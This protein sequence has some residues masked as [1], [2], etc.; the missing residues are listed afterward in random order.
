MIF[1]SI[2]LIVDLY[3]DRVLL[4]GSELERRFQSRRLGEAV[5]PF[6]RCVRVVLLAKRRRHCVKNTN[7]A[8]EL[9]ANSDFAVS[10]LNRTGRLLP[11]CAEPSGRFV[12]PRARKNSALNHDNP[13]TR[14]L[15]FSSRTNTHDL[16][17]PCSFDDVLSK[18]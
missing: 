11:E 6:L 7:A 2:Y 1:L 12:T 8:D 4:A 18:F 16:R 3:L 17:A 9:S 15:V 14:K 5:D 10:D 13:Y